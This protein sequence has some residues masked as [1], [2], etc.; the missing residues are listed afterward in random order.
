LT[1]HYNSEGKLEERDIN[2]TSQISIERL[3]TRSMTPD[4]SRSEVKDSQDTHGKL[5]ERKLDTGI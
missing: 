5:V 4:V 3:V 2:R 1:K